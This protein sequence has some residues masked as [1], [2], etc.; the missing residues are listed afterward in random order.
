VLN[1]LHD[2][3]Y[4][5]RLLRRAP[6][7]AA[8][9]V[10]SLALGIGANTTIFTFVH[11]VLLRPLPVEEP[12]QLVAV[13]T[14]DQRNTGGFNSYLQ[15]PWLNYKDYRERNRAFTSLVA[16]QVATVSLSSG[17]GEPMQTVGEI[18]GGDYF[19][20]L[21]V[22]PV[23]GRGF[24]PD[25]DVTPGAKLVTVLSYGLWQ[26][27]FGG[28]PSLVGRTITINSHPFTVVG[29]APKGFRGTTTVGG[30]TLW[31][32][33]MTYPQ[34]TTGFYL[35]GFISR[36]SLFFDLVGRLKPGVTVQQAEADLQ[37]IA[38]QL[39]K[40]Y[41]NENA[42][43]NVVVMPLTQTTINPVLHGRF[44]TAGG[45]L[46]AIVALVLLIACANVANLLLARAAVR[47]KEIAVRLSLGASRGRVARQL[48]A[49]SAILALGGGALGLLLAIWAQNIVWTFRPPFLEPDALDL[50]P[51]LTVLAFT[52]IVAIATG[53]LFG[54]APVLR[55]RR[56]DLVTELKERSSAPAGSGGLFSAR[57]LLVAA[58]MALSL[59]ALVAAGLFLRSLYH[60]QQ[61][62]LGFDREELA[63][64]SF[65][66]GSQGD[67]EARVREF[68]QQVL[69]RVTAIPGIETAT[70]ATGI[71]FAGGAFRRTVFLEGQ[72]QTDRRAGTLVQINQIGPNYFETFGIRLVRG[73]GFDAS[74]RPGG[75]TVIIINETMARMFWKDRDPIGGRFR[76]YNQKNFQ[77]VV[78]V[79]KDSL[80][81]SIGESPTPYAYQP[82]EQSGSPYASLFVRTSRPQALLGTVRREVQQIDRTLPL[83]A[84]STMTEM[85]DQA[86]W[87]SRMAAW[88]LAIFAGL[89]LILAVIGLY[90][91]M[92][93]LV[94]QRTRELGI[95]VALGATR[96][97]VLRLVISQA[98]R[99]TL[100]GL[101]I[102]L[103]AS[104]AAS[105]LVT[106]LLY[107]VS[108]TDPV[109][110]V[111]VPILLALVALLASY[112]PA[113]RATR[114]DPITALR[115][116]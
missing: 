68:Y 99:L 108:A 49:E 7:F 55:V 69:T 32:P 53:L 22:R 35:Q 102:G 52:T 51:D 115:T 57:G 97:Q 90:G 100:A 21:G 54:M 103:A 91:V 60:A 5:W 28:D 30:P 14:T 94:A 107:D 98:A 16:H 45:I 23:L 4:G 105:R 85:L 47:H 39:E 63:M 65:A 64:L 34:V 78:G 113:R 38:R 93:F 101:L 11:A 3:R 8:A 71:P 37:A 111:S 89:S 75:Q 114:I 9:A 66:P 20:L 31:V 29:I 59:I 109:T 25:E 70:I 43:R 110:F 46:M 112:V 17:A 10:L 87:S 73:R 76:F 96:G 61:I 42:G 72:D 56:P 12:S 33:A 67:D 13:Y 79:V 24:L 81:N 106:S 88:L 50:S 95:R 19:S 77:V 62:P 86:M 18:V 82:L 80:Y 15:T 41:P 2:V 104:F 83:T 116:E 58:Q 44:V 6:G 84:V 74:D 48:L 36:R 92:V 27:R 40:E 1:L 26:S